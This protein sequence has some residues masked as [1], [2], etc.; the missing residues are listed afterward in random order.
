MLAARLTGLLPPPTLEESLEITRIHDAVRPLGGTLLSRRPF[1]APHHTTSRAG[2]VGGGADLRPGEATLAHRGVLFLDELAEFSRDALEALRQPLEEGRVALARASS[3]LELPARFQLVGARNPCPC[4]WRGHPVRPCVCLPRDL[5]RYRGR[6]SGPLLDRIDLSLALAPVAASELGAAGAGP[7]TEA[8]R[9]RAAAARDRQVARA[10][11][12]NA[13]L[14]PRELAR[15]ASLD[16]ASRSLLARALERLG[17]S[18]RGH[19][20]VLRV[21]RTIADLEGS[22]RV[23]TEHVVEALAFRAPE[24]DGAAPASDS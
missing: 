22:E 12:E 2:L 11:R 18:M 24:E 13:R 23:R 3:R 20:R 14:R 17:L 16:A 15:A 6:V 10:G 9:E 8:Q 7:T 1:R 21:A 5:A 4:G 19:A